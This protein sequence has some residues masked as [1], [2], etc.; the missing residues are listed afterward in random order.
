MYENLAMEGFFHWAP[1][2][3]VKILLFDHIV[4]RFPS[5]MT[6]DLLFKC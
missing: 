2:S 5:A 6:L 4:F 1:C 3:S